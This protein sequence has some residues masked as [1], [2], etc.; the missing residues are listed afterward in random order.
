VLVRSPLGV[1]LIET[2][3]AWAQY[4]RGGSRRF[5]YRLNG[6]AFATD[7][8]RARGAHSA[9]ELSADQ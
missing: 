4:K 1:S 6:R 8:V 9:A 3:S 7:T 5:R 2:P